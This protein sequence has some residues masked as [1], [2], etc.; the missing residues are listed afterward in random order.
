MILMIFLGHPKK[1]N[2]FIRASF[3]TQKIVFEKQL[4]SKVMRKT[5]SRE[6]GVDEVTEQEN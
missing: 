5:C 1:S 6:S 2:Q 3:V 4:L